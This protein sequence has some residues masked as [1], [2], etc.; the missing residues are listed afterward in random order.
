M[1]TKLPH[2]KTPCFRKKQQEYRN[3]ID[4]KQ[5]KSSKRC[6]DWKSQVK[7]EKYNGLFHRKFNPK[8][9]CLYIEIF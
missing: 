5:E 4:S 6:H 3:I 7:C 1:N 2:L 8:T 9:F